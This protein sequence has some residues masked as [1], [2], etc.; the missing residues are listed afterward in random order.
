MR[1]ACLAL[2]NNVGF[3]TSTQPT[4]DKAVGWVERINGFEKP[5]KFNSKAKPNAVSLHP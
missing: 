3:R 1:F 4:F 5:D 2:P